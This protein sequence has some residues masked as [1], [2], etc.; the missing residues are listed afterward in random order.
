MNKTIKSYR[1]LFFSSKERSI[2]VLL[3][4]IIE[5]ITITPLCGFL[6]QCGCH[7]PWLGLDEKCNFH[8]PQI[9]QQ[10]P[11]CVSII[12]GVIS[13]SLAMISGLYVSWRVQTKQ[14]ELKEIVIRTLFGLCAFALTAFIM[15]MVAAS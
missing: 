13:T 9:E 14:Q 4:L 6:F 2:S 8:Q 3:V 15:S 5:L 1:E 7:W 12:M 10:C 11:W